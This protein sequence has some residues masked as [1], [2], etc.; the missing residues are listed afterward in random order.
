[1]IIK[2]H[3]KNYEVNIKDDFEFINE[4]KEMKNS[5]F[6]IDRNVYKIYKDKLFSDIN[7]ERI[8]L[9]D[10]LE[11][12]KNIETALEICER[13][14]Q[15]SAKRNALLISIGG[16]I[17]QDVTG[18]VA[19]ILY[20]GINWILVPTT[21][22]SACDSCIGSKTSLN[23]KNYKN[24]LGTFYPPD[25]LYICSKFFN[26]LTD[27]DFNSGLGEVVKFNVM[28]GTEGVKLIEENL[29]DLMKREANP[30]NEFVNRSLNFKI[31]F[32]EKDEFD[33]GD[34]IYLNFAHTFGHAFETVSKYKIP[35]GLAVALGMLVANRISVSRGIFDKEVAERIEKLCKKI[36]TIDIKEEWFDINLVVDAIRK[37]KKQTSDSLTAVLLYDDFNIGIFNNVTEEELSESFSHVRKLIIK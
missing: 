35:H 12:K 9:I 13:F 16:G 26:T 31:P 4:L 27:T 3:F 8:Y 32:I 30:L 1:M 5:L 7:E 37:D 22:L 24:L 25:K 6:A 14:T 34:R 33:K 11:E 20:R 21:L 18:F 19:N 23:Y 36:L 2:S 28:A 29:E 15:M 10:A 17:V